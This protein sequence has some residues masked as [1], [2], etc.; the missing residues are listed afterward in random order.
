MHFWVDPRL[1]DLMQ[2]LKVLFQPIPRDAS[3]LFDIGSI[4]SYVSSYFTSYLDFPHS[5]LNI[6]VHISTPVGDSIVVDSVYWS[7]F[8]TIGLYETSVDLL[9]LGIVDFNVIFSMD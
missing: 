2:L 5:S 6:H 9:L 7:Y 8:V 3:V 1:R 4:Y